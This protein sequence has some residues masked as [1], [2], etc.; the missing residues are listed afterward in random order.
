MVIKNIT[1]HTAKKS[2]T[3]FLLKNTIFITIKSNEIIVNAQ[4]KIFKTGIKEHAGIEKHIKQKTQQIVESIIASL[5][6][7]DFVI[8]WILNFI[9]LKNKK[10]LCIYNGQ[11]N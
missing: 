5:L 8:S 11:Q 6:D 9:I 10:F 1:K 7:G 2:K 4:V 3:I